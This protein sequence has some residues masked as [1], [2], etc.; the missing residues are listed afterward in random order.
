VSGDVLR[1]TNVL[2]VPKLM[3]SVLSVS[4]IEK[5]GYYVLFRDGHVLF[6]P[7]GFSFKSTVVLGVREGNLYRLRG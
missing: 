7:R 5:K 2:W 4:E 1:V 3:R 6:V